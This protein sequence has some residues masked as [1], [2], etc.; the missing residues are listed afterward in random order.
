MVRIGIGKIGK[1]GELRELDGFGV[2]I[3][4]AIMFTTLPV[5]IHA[6][7]FLVLDPRGLSG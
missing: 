3:G 5:N 7:K 1:I 6:E 4:R 2:R